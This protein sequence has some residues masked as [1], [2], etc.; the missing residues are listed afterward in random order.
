MKD[1]TVEERGSE[2]N[3]VDKLVISRKK[4]INDKR[5]YK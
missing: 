3:V 5:T 1:S 2:K 4:M